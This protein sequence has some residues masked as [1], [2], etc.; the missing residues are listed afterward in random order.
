[1]ASNG[2]RTARMRDPYPQVHQNALRT[3]FRPWTLGT[4]DPLVRV[5]EDVSVRPG[6]RS[7]VITDPIGDLC[8]GVALTRQLT[9]DDV[10]QVVRMA[11]IPAL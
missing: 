4:S 9:D 6:S 8:V 11:G 10:T 7:S 1:M 2:P 3:S 5:D